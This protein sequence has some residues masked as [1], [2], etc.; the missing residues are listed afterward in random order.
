MQNA[1]ACILTQKKVVSISN[2]FPIWREVSSNRR[3]SLRYCD[4]L[5]S[6]VLC[7][8]HVLTTWDLGDEESFLI[9]LTSRTCNKRQEYSQWFFFK[10]Q[11]FYDFYKHIVH[12]WYRPGRLKQTFWELKVCFSLSRSVFFDYRY[13]FVESF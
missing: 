7:N 8:M 3:E 2:F 6:V 5:S 4:H 10:F 11:G 13:D 1:T 9:W 12:L